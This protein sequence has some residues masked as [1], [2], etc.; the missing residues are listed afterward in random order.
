MQEQAIIR[1]NAVRSLPQ[2]VD[3]P[4][5][6]MEKRHLIGDYFL[7]RLRWPD[8]NEVFVDGPDVEITVTKKGTIVL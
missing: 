1:G 5:T 3:I 6:V 7:V 8:G 4:A 2:Y